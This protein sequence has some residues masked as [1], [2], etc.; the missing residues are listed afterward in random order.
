[1]ILAKLIE[2]NN[3]RLQEET[4]KK[5]I[6]YIIDVYAVYPVSKVLNEHGPPVNGTESSVK[7]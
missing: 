3:F 2:A 7:N 6:M 1:M 4:Y 5:Y